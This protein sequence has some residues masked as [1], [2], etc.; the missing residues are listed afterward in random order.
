[1]GILVILNF[2]PTIDLFFR[3]KVDISTVYLLIEKYEIGDIKAL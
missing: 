2:I 1:M 3:T